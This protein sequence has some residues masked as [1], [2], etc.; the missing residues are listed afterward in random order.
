MPENITGSGNINGVTVSYVGTVD[1]R[2]AGLINISRSADP[3]ANKGYTYGVT[4][5]QKNYEVAATLENGD[6]VAFNDG[7]FVDTAY[8]ASDAVAHVDGYYQ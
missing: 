8:A 7:V 1:T 6:T 4:W 3:L 5:N 2:L